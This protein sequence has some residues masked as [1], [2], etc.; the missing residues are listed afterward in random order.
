M[1]MNE[2]RG[3]KRPLR[4]IGL[5]ALV[6]A[7]ATVSRTC[8]ARGDGMAF[9]G[10]RALVVQPDVVW[11]EWDVAISAALEERGFEVTYGP[12]L[13]DVGALSQYDLVALNIRRHL[14]DA[15]AGALQS[16][17]SQGGALYA[18]WGGP[19]GAPELMRDVFRAKDP[20][21]IYI[22]HMTLLESPI[23][24][25]IGE[26]ELAL[27]EHVGHQRMAPRGWEIVAMDPLGGGVPVAKAPAGE[28]LGV[29]SQCGAGRAAVLGFGAEQEKYLAR[30]E[31]G[32]RMLDNL[33]TW[34]LQGR[35]E[36]GPWHWSERVTVSLPA[37]AQITG[38]EVNGHQS[39][40]FVARRVGSLR[41]V[42]IAVGEIAQG[43]QAELRITYEPLSSERS[44]ETMIHLPWG[45]LR[46]AAASPARLAEYLSSLN[47][48]IC[49]P[50]LRGSDGHAWYRGMPE[51]RPDEKVVTEYDGNFLA[52][53]IRECQARGMQVIGGVYFD[54][55]TPVRTYPEVI[56]LD[57]RGQGKHD[58]YGNPYACFNNPKGQE[59]N[60]ATIEQLLAEYD[61]D[62]VI[63]DDNYE[64]D[65]YVND[66][67]CAYCEAGFRTYCEARGIEYHGPESWSSAPSPRHDYRRGGTRSLV[68]KVK[69]M[70]AARGRIAG[71][72]VSV[73]RDAAH[74]ANSL[75]FLG[76]MAYT[77]P[78]RSARAVLP[79]LGECDFICLLWAPNSSP[80]AMEREA[81]EAIHAGCAA[82]GFWVMGEDGGYELDPA[83]SEAIRRA[84]ANVER[85]WRAFYRD[86]LLGG[87]G[88]FAV[89]SGSVGPAELRLVIRN[90]GARVSRR[91]QG[92]IALEIPPAPPRRS[93]GPP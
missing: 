84:F 72:W 58:R 10:L 45:T 86:N 61:L 62:G 69:S 81:K 14:R 21:S 70:A 23:S 5:A 71:G 44:V 60:L 2:D 57:G 54:N 53:L 87:D 74:L 82:I 34:L 12:P 22:T 63:L 13:S 78:P 65:W 73:T 77:S 92:E 1:S 35:A 64:L 32:P 15:E 18:S 93:A 89:V 91:V 66:C 90:T 41:E 46:S 75:D 68:A 19:M 3:R 16:Y 51:D 7:V 76:G 47:A 30:P 49:Q 4:R 39:G 43:D 50:L 31:L 25:G 80:M 88:R 36:R 79:L 8:A 24:A 52:D 56:Q 37:R 40:E 26:R 27:A 20:R 59:H 29:L 17:V 28:V 38:V 85:E 48:T 42:E 33:L 67:H 9:L 55:T 83:R 11:Q 6:L